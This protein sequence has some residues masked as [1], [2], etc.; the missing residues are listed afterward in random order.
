[1]TR[2]AAITRIPRRVGIVVGFLALAAVPALGLS[3]F[4]AA[5]TAPARPR[6]LDGQPGTP[7]AHPALT[8]AQK[9]CLADHGVTLP[10][11]PTTLEPGQRP[12][13]P[14]DEQRQ[15]APRGRPGVR[16]ADSAAGRPPARW[17]RFRASSPPHGR[18]E[19]VSGRSGC[20]APA[21][22]RPP[23]T[24]GQPPSPPTAEQRAAL[25]QAAAACGITIPER[26]PRDR[27]RTRRGGVRRAGIAVHE[28]THPIPP[29]GGCPRPFSFSSLRISGPTAGRRRRTT[30]PRPAPSR[31]R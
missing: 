26:P 23:A 5:A 30:N 19:A 25:Q 16:A 31:G 22:S 8:D 17:A 28:G 27:E 13:P 18:A 29:T 24:A 1:M 11:R 3:A 15:A 4:A 9:Q 20:H 14:T 6:G 12:T 7:P 21:A 10:E 2:G